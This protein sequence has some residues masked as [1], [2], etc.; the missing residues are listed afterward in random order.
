MAHDRPFN[1]RRSGKGRLED[2]PEFDKIKSAS[3]AVTSRFW[4][5]LVDAV[6]VIQA[7]NA[8]KGRNLIFRPFSDD[9]IRALA[10]L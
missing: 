10:I 1:K 4:L 2:L 3:I 7:E 9:L 5:G 6:N 8:L